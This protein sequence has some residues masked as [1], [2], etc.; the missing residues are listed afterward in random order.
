MPT[1][2]KLAGIVCVALL[3]ACGGGSVAPPPPS[4][5]VVTSFALAA[6]Y[7]KRISQGFTTSY[8]V[9]GDCTGW[10]TKRQEVPKSLETFDGNLSA[11]PAEGSTL[12]VYSE[13]QP[14]TSQSAYVNYYDVNDQLLGHTLSSVDTKGKVTPVEYGVLSPAASPMPSFAKVGDGALFGAETIYTDSSKTAVLG[15]DFLSYA[16][17][18]GA[19]STSTAIVNLITERYDSLAKT[20]LIFKQQARAR[21]AEDGTLTDMTIE[22]Q[23]GTSHL[24][25]TV[26]Q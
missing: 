21:M 2:I 15:Y 24:V 4:D 5:K 1:L 26:P 25:F 11:R 7:H 16:I 14:A 22:L 8:R 20:H 3:S 12:I 13:C 17:E 23:S 10:A 6:G 9:S 19:P 18:T